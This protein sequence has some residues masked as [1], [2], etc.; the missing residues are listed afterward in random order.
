VQAKIGADKCP[1]FDLKAGGSGF[2]F[3]LEIGRQFVA[4][5]TIDTALVIGAEKLSSVLDW[6]DRT[7]CTLF[8]DGAGAVVLRPSADRAGVLGGTLGSN[9]TDGDLL[10]LNAGGSRIP[11]SRDSVLRGLHF[12]RM[13]SRQT[14]KQAVRALCDATESVLRENGLTLAA[15]DCIIPHQSNQRIID[16]FAKR[17]KAAPAQVFSNLESCGNTS[18]ASLPIALAAAVQAG[19]VKPGDL[20][21]LA[22]FGSG[23]TWGAT[24]VRW[25]P[26]PGRLEPSHLESLLPGQHIQSRPAKETKGRPA[27]TKPPVS[28]KTPARKTAAD[29]V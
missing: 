3:A 1:A 23:L 19:R 13:Q 18:A 15:I 9:G 16:V 8:G 4:S 5:N 11:A 20:V 27:A 6:H 14:F 12:L 22:G 28:S 10:V 29:A 26:T 17:I 25:Q 7:T 2:L 24:I 21:L